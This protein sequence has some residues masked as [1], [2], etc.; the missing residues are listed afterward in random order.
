MTIDH[1]ESS[2]EGNEDLGPLARRAA[3]RLL[4]TLDLRSAVE[5][6]IDWQKRGSD[7]AAE[8]W[9]KIQ[10]I[11][12]MAAVFQ[13]VMTEL[14]SEN[15]GKDP[16]SVEE[17]C[18]QEASYERFAYG[19]MLK[20]ILRTHPA[21]QL[22]LP[23]WITL[24]GEAA[25]R[26]KSIKNYAGTDI[27]SLGD[28]ILDLAAETVAE[29]AVLLYEMMEILHEE[30]WENG[31]Q[32]LSEHSRRFITQWLEDFYCKDVDTEALADQVQELNLAPLLKRQGP[33][34]D[35]VMNPRRQFARSVYHIVD[36][37]GD[38][39][40]SYTAD[41]LDELAKKE[42]VKIGTHSDSLPNKEILET[43]DRMVPEKF[44]ANVALEVLNRLRDTAAGSLAQNVSVN[45]S[46]QLEKYFREEAL[47]NK[48]LKEHL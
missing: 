13:E 46:S 21:E 6:F 42:E 18:N 33:F 34:I 47:H 43:I 29:D 2:P 28:D 16:E 48:L 35:R 24:V 20:D 17:E 19:E 45:A 11:D 3:A 44:R 25:D 4:P 38:A 30:E 8:E 10:E 9:G 32:I 12:P 40:D 22:T 14:I 5:K 37:K 27:M 31:Y 26:H 23:R 36:M 15:S 1:P 41:V 39:A 7:S